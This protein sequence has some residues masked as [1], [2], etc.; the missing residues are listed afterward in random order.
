MC[1]RLL[2]VEVLKSSFC[3]LLV[4]DISTVGETCWW[5]FGEHGWCNYGSRCVEKLGTTRKD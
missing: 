3:A 1:E 4:R 5:L 2:L